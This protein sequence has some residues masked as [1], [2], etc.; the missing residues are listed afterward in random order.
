MSYYAEPINHIK[1]EVR[2]VLDLAN[3]ATKKVLEHA[4]GFDRS[5]LAAKSILL[6]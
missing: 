3:N 6:L 4:A 5:D 1:D 2:V